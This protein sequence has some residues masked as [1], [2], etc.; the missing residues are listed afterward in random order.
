MKKKIVI[1]FLALG[2][3]WSQAGQAQEWDLRTCLEIGL[4]QNPKIQAVMQAV[5]GAGARVK[6]SLA[7]YYPSLFAET[8]YSR[9]RGSFSVAN[10]PRPIFDLYAYYLGLT[11]NI[12]DFGRREYKIESSKEDLKAYQWDLKDV[13]LAVIDEIRQAY[14]GALLTQRIVKVRQEDLART[15]VHF[16]Q[17]QAFYQIGLKAKIDFTQAE[18]E[19]IKVQKA[20]L[21]A[22][23]DAKV[24]LVSLSKA[25]GFDRPPSF[26]LKDKLEPERMG[27]QLEDL[28]KEALEKHTILNRIKAVIK[29]WEAQEKWAL[30]E[31]WP[32]MTG[33]A[34]YGWSGS[35]S[36]Y[37]ESW[38]VGVQVNFPFF[39]GFQSQAKL[40]EIRAAANQAKANENT[41]RLQ[42]LNDLQ[43]Q[44]LNHQLAEKQIE[45]ARESLRSAK[46][47]WEQAMGRYKSGIG[48]ML[49]VTDAR[50]SYSQAE[51]DYVQ[52]LYD[53]QIVRYQIE[54][55]IGRE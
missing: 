55:T 9:Y 29:Y 2:T 20:L 31:F 15:Q 24:S 46:D 8:D 38:M 43:S 11:Q 52:A 12:Y 33:T 35:N 39:S 50:V 7:D 47:N 17:A 14:F 3:F 23:N 51:N 36:P 32:K 16:E 42:V 34:K 53:Y 19:L 25:M 13:R 41:L 4:K 45:V 21:K 44:Y 26:T 48:A 1:I 30:R 54:K 6:Q 22:Q 37:D 18:V 10:Y 27:W 40:A 28:Q 49:E 5:E